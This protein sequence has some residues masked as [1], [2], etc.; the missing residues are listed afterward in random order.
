VFYITGRLYSRDE[1]SFPRNLI[2]ESYGE[3]GVNWI[4]ET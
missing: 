2:K 3:V 1:R 4:W